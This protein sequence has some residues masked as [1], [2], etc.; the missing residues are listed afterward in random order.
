MEQTRSH[1]RHLAENIS[2]TGGRVT[3]R[4]FL[5]ALGALGAGLGLSGCASL[6]PRNLPV[7]PPEPSPTIL[8]PT[9]PPILPPASTPTGLS[10]TGAA[11]TPLPSATPSPTPA[12]TWPVHAL[13]LDFNDFIASRQQIPALEKR[14]QTAGVNLVALGAGRPDWSYFKWQGQEA[15]WSGDVQTSGVDFLME[16]CLRFNQWAHTNAVVDVYA[17]KYIQA[18]PDEAALTWL[19]KPSQYLVNT[20]D[21]VEGKFGELLLSMIE[22]IAARYPV[23]SI[24][25][26]ELVYH[27]DGYGDKDRAAYMAYAKARD[28]PRLANG[29]V[30]TDDPS[31]GVWRTYEIGR[32]LQKARSTANRHG[33][34]LF[35][36]VSV[37]WGKPDL[38]SQ[39]NGT[40]YDLML[41]QADQLVVWDYFALNGYQ[42]EFT[43]NL[44]QTLK[45]Y[46]ENRVILSVGLW[47]KNNRVI[48]GD[49]LERA[50]TS[51]VKGGIRNHWVTPSLLLNDEHW[52]ILEK[53]WRTS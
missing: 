7:L 53:M 42:P 51:A 23:A 45:G 44:A 19:G 16:D 38:A 35:M 27:N 49:Q 18:N 25:L 34:L 41:E 10:P 48:S 33:K 9:E 15:N 32:F 17:P 22:D 14:M 29:L 30:N 4:D 20:M 40:R 47:S 3:R 26:T 6:L 36:D 39:E 43:E 12:I 11:P 28:W 31:I 21:L 37:S 1:R 50:L 2:V 13:R 5:R 46:G 52:S 24:S 8:L